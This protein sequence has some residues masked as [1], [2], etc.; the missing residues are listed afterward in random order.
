MHSPA[1]CS[2]LCLHKH[3]FALAASACEVTALAGVVHAH[4]QAIPSHGTCHHTQISRSSL[5]AKPSER[6]PQLHAQR[7][8]L[9]HSPGCP[10]ICPAQAHCPTLHSTDQSNPGPCPPQIKAFV[11]LAA[12]L[13]STSAATSQRTAAAR[14]QPG[15]GLST[16]IVRAMKDGGMVAA[17]TQVGGRVGRLARPAAPC[18]SFPP[19]ASLLPPWHEGADPPSA[20][21]VCPGLASS[22]SWLRLLLKERLWDGAPAVPLTPALACSAALTAYLLLTVPL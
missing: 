6:L 14:G 11:D 2:Q 5:S 19:L 13:L 1:H 15:A 21:R 17:L 12:F 8:P 3:V 16:E 7:Q 20:P 22:G 10:A 9:T 4:T 18:A